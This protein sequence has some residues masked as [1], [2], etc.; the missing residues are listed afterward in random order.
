MT[1]ET[2]LVLFV[3]PCPQV[4]GPRIN[5]YFDKSFPFSPVLFFFPNFLFFSSSSL[6]HYLSF[7]VEPPYEVILSPFVLP[8][9]TLIR[10]L[11]Y[12]FV[13]NTSWKESCLFDQNTP[14][15]ERTPFPRLFCQYFPCSLLSFHLQRLFIFPS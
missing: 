6:V 12:A 8:P 2:S 10:P 13:D 9:H 3:F 7:S 1:L 5:P 11:F 4:A 15:Q 14:S